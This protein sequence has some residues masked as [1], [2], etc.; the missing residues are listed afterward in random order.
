MNN[1]YTYKDTITLLG[2]GSLIF[3]IGMLGSLFLSG[4]TIFF[5]GMSISFGNHVK[6]L[7]KKLIEI[8]KINKEINDGSGRKD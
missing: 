7:N 6:D 2:I 3:I 4:P 5:V 8:D 1:T